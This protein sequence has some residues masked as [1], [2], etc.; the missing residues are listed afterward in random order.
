M[1]PERAEQIVKEFGAFLSGGAPIINDA[2]LLT[3]PKETIDEAHTVMIRW[4]RHQSGPEYAKYIG[5][6]EFCQVALQA[7]APIDPE[8][9]DMVDYFNQF[10]SIGAIPKEEQKEQLDLFMKYRSRGMK[11]WMQ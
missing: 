1:T 4:L 7:F 5:S 3:Y 10:E 2:G 11:E 6:L 8:D 9:Q